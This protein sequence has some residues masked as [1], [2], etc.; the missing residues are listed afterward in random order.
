M[1]GAKKETQLGE[2]HG[3][4]MKKTKKNR[5]KKVIVSLIACFVVVVA[6]SGFIFLRGKKDKSY[7]SNRQSTISL[8][9]MDLTK[10]ISATGTVNSRKSKSVS[11]AVQDV[12]IKKL[13]VQ[14]GDTVNKGDKLV[15]FD[16]SDLQEALSDAEENLSDI[17]TSA[18]KEIASAQKQYD[19]AVS[20]KKSD[21]S[22]QAKKV[23]KAKQEKK[24]AAAAVKTAKKNLKSAKNAQ[25]KASCQESLTKAEETLKQAESTLE[26][27]I[28]T[29][30]NT[31][32][33][34]RSSVENASSSL[35]TTRSNAEKSIKEARKQVEE[36]REALDQCSVTAPIS[37]IV[38]AVNAEA[39][40]VYSGDS[41][42]Q[43]DDTSAYVV[44]TSVDEYDVSNV[45]VGQRVVILTEATDEDELEGKISFVA[46]SL[47]TSSTSSGSQS[48]ETSGMSSS[49]SSSGYEVTVK[50]TDTDERLRMGLTAK[51]SIILEEVQDIYAVPY[52]AV[53]EDSD[54]SYYINVIGD[55]GTEG[56]DEESSESSE[57][58]GRPDK[59]SGNGSDGDTDKASGNSSDEN[60]GA[61]NTR[62]IT[63]TKGMESDYYVEISGDSLSEGLKVVIPT[64]TVSGSSDSGQSQSGIDLPGMGGGNTDGG[65]DGNKGGGMP[66][67]GMP[68]G[69]GRP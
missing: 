52:D 63:V 57:Q 8:E 34:D 25:E 42:L 5:K 23:A 32:K 16:E 37:G 69:G 68:G 40:D 65:F 12:R 17:R 58:R 9:K 1:Y 54:G 28:E 39:G 47:Q 67:G 55:G 64:D 2:R 14:V 10:S 51:C 21:T 31:L 60:T 43:I 46:P 29:R 41:L 49:N 24:E 22:D 13:L 3:S 33:Q 61:A 15:E 53:H 45:E 36:A 7:A 35:E 66:G 56:G 38:T 20:T 18:N 44:T 62:K 11:A 6:V 30:R 48:G 26:N 19:S 59:D 27:A 50:L 4:K